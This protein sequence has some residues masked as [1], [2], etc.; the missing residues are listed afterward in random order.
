MIQTLTLRPYGALAS[1]EKSRLP[2]LVAAGGERASIR[3]LEFFALRIRKPHTR[4]AY[5]R[6]VTDFLDWCE[7]HAAP[8]IAAVQPLH[9]VAWIEGWTRDLSAP[10]VSSSSPPPSISSTGWYSV[11]CQGRTSFPGNYSTLI[12]TPVTSAQT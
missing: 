5:A 8:S 2:T 11:H 4:R 3:F 7:D 12:D 1:L 10:T 6:A 9:V